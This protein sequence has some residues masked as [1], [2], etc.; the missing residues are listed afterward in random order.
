MRHAPVVTRAAAACLP[1][2]EKRAYDSGTA[3]STA[4]ASPPEAFSL[5]AIFRWRR[6]SYLLTQNK[7]EALFLYVEA[8]S[9]RPALGIG[10]GRRADGGGAAALSA[11]A[12]ADAPRPIRSDR[13]EPPQPPRLHPILIEIARQLG[14]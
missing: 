12:T 14:Q 8:H 9:R 3:A 11:T 1:P 10:N 2:H 7:L 6:H 5:A 4:A 13:F